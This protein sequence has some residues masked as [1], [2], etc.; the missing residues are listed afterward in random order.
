MQRL[1]TTIERLGRVTGESLEI[2]PEVVVKLPAFRVVLRRLVEA[3][4][5]FPEAAGAVVAAL[6]GPS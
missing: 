4:R 1:S 5:P 6:R 2:R 3:L